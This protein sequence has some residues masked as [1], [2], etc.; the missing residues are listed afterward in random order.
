MV[1]RLTGR[2]NKT[3]K[4]TKKRTELTMKNLVNEKTR[5]KLFKTVRKSLGLTQAAMSEKLHI[6]ERAYSDLER[7]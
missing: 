3:S 4:K 5:R 2:Y 1:K 7:G 6:S